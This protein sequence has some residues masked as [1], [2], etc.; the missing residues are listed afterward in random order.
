ML[1]VRCVRVCL[2]R[3]AGVCTGPRCFALRWRLPVLC[4]GDV[5]RPRLRRVGE[6]GTTLSSSPSLRPSY[7]KTSPQPYPA[8]PPS[9]PPALKPAHNPIQLSLPPSLLP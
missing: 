8:L 9:A 7:P 6:G 5:R 3:K 4:G 2:R 1:R